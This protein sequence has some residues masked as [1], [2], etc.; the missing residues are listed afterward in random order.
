M[1]EDESHDDEQLLSPQQK[2]EF[3]NPF[4]SIIIKQVAVNIKSSLLNPSDLI[5]IMY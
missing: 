3:F 1:G 5:N 2:R 4:N